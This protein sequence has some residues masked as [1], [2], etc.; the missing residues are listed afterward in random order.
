[1]VRAYL[2][3]AAVTLATLALSLPSLAEAPSWTVEEGS[4][5]GF[6]TSQGGGR[7]EGQFDRFEAEIAFAPNDLESSRVAVTIDVASVNTE[8]KDRDDT[9][10]SA[11]LFDVATWPQARFEAS[12][13]ET[14]GDNAFDAHGTL[15]LR[16]VTLEVTLPFTL[17]IAEHPDDPAVLKAHAMGELAVD[18]LDYGVG[19]GVWQDTSMVPNQVIIVIDLLASRPKP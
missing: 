15:T 10:R 5:V 7:V 2:V 11:Q 3:M 4:R 16:D 14:T 13:F 18:R 6:V 17:E 8:S 1:M 9:I 12:R 19:Q